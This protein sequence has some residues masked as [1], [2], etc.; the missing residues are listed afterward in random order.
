MH[1][2]H[3]GDIRDLPPLRG[4]IRARCERVVQSER[5]RYQGRLLHSGDTPNSSQTYI[6]FTCSYLQYLAV[7]LEVVQSGLKNIST[8][9]HKSTQRVDYFNQRGSFEHNTTR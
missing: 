5:V 4:S 8:S 3:P 9:P 1:M 6:Q 7:N 2:V